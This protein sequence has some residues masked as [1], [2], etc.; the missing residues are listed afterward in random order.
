MQRV[1]SIIG[2]ARE[3]G[4]A[5]LVLPDGTLGGYLDDLRDPDPI[6]LPAALDIADPLFDRIAELAGE[7]VVCL[8]FCEL[9]ELGRYN[10]AV[11]LS[12]AGVHG[13]HRKVHLA[14]GEHAAYLPGDGF[15]ARDPN[16][17]RDSAYT[18]S[19]GNHNSLCIA[20]RISPASFSYGAPSA[21]RSDVAPSKLLTD[22]VQRPPI[23]V[24]GFRSFDGF[25]ANRGGDRQVP[26]CLT[27][28]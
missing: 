22:K 24:G 3:A 20:L 26:G 2:A 27:S 13:R 18:P 23:A 12:A 25:P 16:M 1:E 28:E 5:I 4:A 8:G 7:L 11:C 14:A 10:A 19:S 17:S 21:P 6:A 15:A 9:T